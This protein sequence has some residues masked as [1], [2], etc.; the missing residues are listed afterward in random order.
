MVKIMALYMMIISQVCTYDQETYL[1][2]IH[3]FLYAHH[4]SIKKYWTCQNIQVLIKKWTEHRGLCFSLDSHF[5]FIA[6]YVY[7]LCLILKITGSAGFLYLHGWPLR[8]SKSEKSLRNLHL[9]VSVP[10]CDCAVKIVLLKL[11]WTYDSLG[12]LLSA[13]S[14]SVGLA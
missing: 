9:C 8:F 5:T 2:N 14:D 3:P 11:L 10:P 6:V 1:K 13:K 4:A 12:F 7:L